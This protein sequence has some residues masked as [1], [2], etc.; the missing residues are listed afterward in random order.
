MTICLFWGPLPSL[1]DCHPL[2]VS[3][4]RNLRSIALTTAPTLAVRLFAIVLLDFP[5]QY[6]LI[7]VLC[8]PNTSLIEWLNS[9][10]NM[11]KAHIKM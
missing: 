5:S 6:T 10:V 2:S 3:H 4:F 8:S 9:Y 1:T 11:R 7:I